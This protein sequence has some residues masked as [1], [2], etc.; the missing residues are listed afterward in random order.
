MPMVRIA[1]VIRR[2][3]DSLS[4]GP[5]V[6]A[7]AIGTIFVAV[8]LTGVFASL[9]SGAERVL[10]AWVREVPISVYLSPGAD[11]SVARAAAESLAPGTKVEVVAPAEALR[12]LRS[13]LGDQ[14]SVLD[15]VGPEVLPAS[16]EALATGLSLEQTRELAARLARIPGATEVDYGAAWLERLETF[17]RRGR[18]VGLALVGLLAL[19]TAVLVANT[20]RLAVYAR[21]DE[22]EIMK[23]VGATDAFVGSPFLV[24]GLLQGLAGAALAVA[25]LLGAAAALLPWLRAALPIASHL[26]RSDLLPGSLLAALLAGGASLGVASSALSLG[27]FLR[28][29]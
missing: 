22:I 24:E 29:V 15:G 21:R 18:R 28:R 12:R 26:S 2:A 7:V 3:V 14:A 11:L 1:L 4:R 10:S 23:L 20:L 27:R 19:A 17:L 13:S 25:A 8:L 9:F 16:V 5:F 6:S